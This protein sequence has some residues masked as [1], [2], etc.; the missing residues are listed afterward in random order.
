MANSTKTARV[1][2]QKPHADFPLFPHAT[3]RWAKKVRRKMR[4]YGPWEDP[5]AAL[6]EWL[7]CKDYHLAGLDAPDPNAPAE[8]TVKTLVNEFLFAKRHRVDNRELSP[9]TFMDYYSTCE[10]VIEHFG[11]N[12]AVKALGPADFL[13]LRMKLAETQGLV[14]L[15]NTI[16]RVRILFNSAFA[17]DMIEKPVKF[18]E[19]FKKPTRKTIRKERHAKGPR[20]F[21]GPEL[22]KLIDKAKSP[23]RAMILLGLNCGYGNNDVATLPLAALDLEKGWVEF[24]R[25]KTEVPRRCPLWPETIAALKDAI[26]KRPEPTVNV[27]QDLV[28]VTRFG[29]KFVRHVM[30]DHDDDSITEAW[31]D[32]VGLQFGKLLLA[33]G[34]KRPG[35]GFYTLRH[36]FET[37]G[38]E[39]RDQVAVDALMGHTDSSMAAQYREGISD[40]RLKAIVEHIR[41]WLPAP[42]R[43]RKR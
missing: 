25:P 10:T 18:G 6:K 7:R 22:R 4:Y 26:K 28:F 14:R 37:I 41:K 12:K 17:E 19:Q 42:K 8:L 20:M 2:P 43:I 29:A 32:T 40:A 11:K 21:T 9:R 30:T 23:M 24:P 1:K 35:L 38:G 34:L 16:T 39:T 15:G 13:S 36:V 27:Q 5:D 33:L 31:I 3:G